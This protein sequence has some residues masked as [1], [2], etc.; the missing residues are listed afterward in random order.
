MLMAIVEE[1]T[2]YPRDMVGLDQNLEADLGID[3]I[4]RIE[5]V[6]ALLQQLPAAH[7]EALTES[8]SKLNTQA[9]L[10]GM[11]DL[12]LRPRTGALPSLL[13]VPG[14]DQ[15]VGDT[16]RRATRPGMVTQSAAEPVPGGRCARAN[17]R[18]PLPDHT[19]HAGRGRCLA[20]ALQRAGVRESCSSTPTNWPRSPLRERSRC[21]HRG[22]RQPV[23]GVLHLAAIG[24]AGARRCRQPGRS[25]AK[26]CSSARRPSFLLL[27]DWRPALARRQ[28]CGRGQCLGG[29]FGREGSATP[30]LRAELRRRRR[31][32]S[33]CARSAP[34]CA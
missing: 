29:L 34:T 14:R 27:R 25:G 12:V 15:Q 17:W 22:W 2:G 26:R 4:K 19:R 30:G 10:N 7:R 23:A 5:V 28:P 18:R 21:C 33:P 31:A 1:K 13:N 8:R 9:T 24:A 16:C 32:S 11:L 3:S 20:D 6:G